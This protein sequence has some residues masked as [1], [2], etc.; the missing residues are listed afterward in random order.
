[1]GVVYQLDKRYGI[2]YAYDSVALWDKDK[3]Q[4]R[5]KRKLIGRVDP[6]SGD[7]IPTD[8]RMKKD[9]GVDAPMSKFQSDEIL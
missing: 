3:H 9:S 6:N 8:G 2:T 4:S 5:A 7:I 1:M